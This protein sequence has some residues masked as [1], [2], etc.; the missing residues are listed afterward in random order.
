MHDTTIRQQLE[1][2]KKKTP[3]GGEYWMARDIQIVLGYAKWDKFEKVLE[4]AMMACA[5]AG[6]NA[7]DHF[8]QTGKLVEAGSGTMV[9]RKDYFLTRYACYLVAMNGDTTKHEIGAAQSY[10][11]VQ[12]RKQEKAEAL[13]AEE[14][15]VQLRERVRDANRKLNSAAKKAG[16]QK[17]GVFHDAGYR[18][19]YEMGLSDI[20][21]RK[22]ISQ[23]E[24]LLDRA[25]RTELAANEFRITQ[26]ED[27]LARDTVE[28][29]QH[30][31][32]THRRVG[33]E[34]RATIMNLGGTMPENLPTEPPIKTIAS[35]IKK[36]KKMLPENKNK[37]D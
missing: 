16:V 4:K 15:R 2:K 33:Q 35:K 26:T 27:K 11:A 21:R 23:E 5:S 24:D 34:V 20:K 13:T 8:L 10:F 25:G 12:T 29:E 14:R 32:E 6:G 18:G 19:L 9:E 22:G 3:I 37:E 7:E 28:N 30:A 1:E 36:E 17:Y 31:I